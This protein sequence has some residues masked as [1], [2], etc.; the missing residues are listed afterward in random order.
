MKKKNILSVSENHELSEI[1]VSDVVSYLP[2]NI[3][4]KK[5]N[6]TTMARKFLKNNLLGSKIATPPCDCFFKNVG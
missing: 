4:T 1:K 6:Y 2:P 5:A 3:I